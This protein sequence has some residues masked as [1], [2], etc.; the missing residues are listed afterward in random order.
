MLEQVVEKEEENHPS[1]MAMNDPEPAI[2]KEEPAPVAAPVQQ[3]LPVPTQAPAPEKKRERPQSAARKVSKP[4]PIEEK[5]VEPLDDNEEE[6]VIVAPDEVIDEPEGPLANLKDVGAI[7]MNDQDEDVVE[8]D[9][10][11]PDDDYEE[12][13]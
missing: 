8:Q 4:V 12:L 2:P 5:V 3:E 7:K 1:A 6:E 10:E 9:G 13:P 11:Q